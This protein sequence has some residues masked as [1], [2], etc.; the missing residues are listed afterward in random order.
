MG[1]GFCVGL[2]GCCPLVFKSIGFRERSGPRSGKVAAA[3]GVKEV[4]DL[5][6]AGNSPAATQVPALHGGHC[7]G[8]GE[9]PVQRPAAQL[10]EGAGAVKDIAG[11]IG[12]HG[13][14]PE[15]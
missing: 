8:T 6:E 3:V 7:I 10:G 12:V 5:R 4:A 11:A 13:L 15:P 14:D 2:A 1:L 9:D